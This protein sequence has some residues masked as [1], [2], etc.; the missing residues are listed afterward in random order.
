[1]YGTLEFRAFDAA[2]SWETQEEHIAFY[3]RYAE[4][5]IRKYKAAYGDVSGKVEGFPT[6]KLIPK[7]YT[8]YRN[9]KDKCIKD[10]K[11]LIVDELELPWE[12]YEWYIERNL[13]SAFEFG[14]RR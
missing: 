3:Q 14:A 4:M 6:N 10:F 1:M 7:I 13:N 5:C 8:S 11:K 12:R 9:N 2:D